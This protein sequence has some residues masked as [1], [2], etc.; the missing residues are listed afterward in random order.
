MP[1]AEP[2]LG[3]STLR[4]LP[5]ISH[6]QYTHKKNN[7]EWIKNVLEIMTLLPGRKTCAF[8]AHNKPRGDVLSPYHLNSL[9]P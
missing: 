2:P 4:S 7:Y 1:R 6:D 3:T 9:S 5:C 8:W